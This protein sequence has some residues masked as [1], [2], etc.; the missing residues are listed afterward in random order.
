MNSIKML[1]NCTCDNLEMYERV[2]KFPQ[3]HYI[4]NEDWTTSCTCFFFFKNRR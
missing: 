4:L 3:H 2:A 1:T